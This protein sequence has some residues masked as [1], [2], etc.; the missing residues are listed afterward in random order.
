[1]CVLIKLVFCFFCK[2]RSLVQFFVFVLVFLGFLLGFVREYLQKLQLKV[3]CSTLC[4]FL[5]TY[6]NKS[7]FSLFRLSKSPTLS[8]SFCCW[9]QSK[10]GIFVVVA[11]KTKLLRYWF[12]FFHVSCLCGSGSANFCIIKTHPKLVFLLDGNMRRRRR[13]GTP[14][15][16]DTQTNLPKKKHI[17]V[18]NCALRALS[19]SIL[20]LTVVSLFLSIA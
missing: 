19:L 14:A 10:T 18:N 13:P 15:Q 12:C 11:K 4:S 7:P 20:C 2:C 3:E 5:Y 9:T 16:S 1:M 6:N 8:F 17:F